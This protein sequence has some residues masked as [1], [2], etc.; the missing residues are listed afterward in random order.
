MKRYEKILNEHTD[1]VRLVYDGI[2]VYPKLEVMEMLKQS[3]WEGFYAGAMLMWE[4]G[5]DHSCA[6]AV[7]R[8]DF[9]TWRNEEVTDL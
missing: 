2:Q 9:E 3:A 1:K 6:E 8:E 5:S 7:I 4:P